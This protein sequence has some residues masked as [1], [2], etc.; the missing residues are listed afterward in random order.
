M[1][2]ITHDLG[3]VAGTCDRVN[4]LY[5]GRVVEQ[6]SRDDLFARP[7]PPLHAGPAGLRAPRRTPP[8]ARRCSPSRAR[9]RDRPA[10]APGCAFAPALRVRRRRLPRRR[11]P[12]CAGTHR[13]GAVR[14]PRRRRPGGHPMTARYPS[15]DRCRATAAARARPAGPLPD[16][17]GILQRTV[18]AGAGRRRGRP[19]RRAAAPPTAWWGSPVR[20]VDAG[21]GRAAA[22]RAHRR[23]RAHRRAGPAGHGARAAAPRP[24]GRCRWS[25]RTRSPASTPARPSRAPWWSRCACTGSRAAP[26]P[27]A[28]GCAACWTGWACPP[29]R[30][31]QLPARVL[32]RAAPAR[33]HRPRAGAGPRPARRRRAGL[34]PRR[35]RPGAGPGPAGGAA[36]RPGADLPRHRPRPR[37]G[38]AHQRPRSG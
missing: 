18:G 4:V 2:L 26:R 15:R 24:R 16:R 31:D 10:W 5:A 20:E 23:L 1:V 8:R 27:G 3:V 25:S 28:P 21:P 33:R 14:A 34:R 7:A 29:A 22:D 12:R 32:R 38:Q 19:R 9:C 36:A 35:V 17:S 11:H 13:P 6:A 37:R 30:G